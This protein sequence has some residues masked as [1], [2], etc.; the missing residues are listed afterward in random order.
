MVCQVLKLGGHKCRGNSLGMHVLLCHMR[1]VCGL[2]IHIS[3][4]LHI[5]SN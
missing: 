2:V 5:T 1:V 3:L 4:C